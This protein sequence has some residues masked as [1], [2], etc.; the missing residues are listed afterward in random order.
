MYGTFY[1][2]MNNYIQQE[3]SIRDPDLLMQFQKKPI[4]Q[5]FLFLNPCKTKH[6]SDKANMS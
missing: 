1:I 2:K 3:V 6:M 5:T 4:R